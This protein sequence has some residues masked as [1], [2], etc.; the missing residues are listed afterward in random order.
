MTGLR[1]IC[2]VFPAAALLAMAAVVGPA[3]AHDGDDHSGSGSNSGKAEE[4]SGP[5]ENSGDHPTPAEQKPETPG[6][7][8][9]NEGDGSDELPE[10]ETPERGKHL[11]ASVEHGI[12]LVR[13]PG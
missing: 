9:G 5:D 3:F 7:K 8:G 10:T 1:L 11:N 6:D 13:M 12:I 2:P 4:H